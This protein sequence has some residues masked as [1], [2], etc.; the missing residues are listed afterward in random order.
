MIPMFRVFSSVKVRG[1]S[2]KNF[3]GFVGAVCRPDCGHEKGPG[4]PIHD[5]AVGKGRGFF[6]AAAPTPWSLPPRGGNKGAQTPPRGH[7]TITEGP[8]TP[9]GADPRRARGVRGPPRP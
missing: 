4:G 7:P 2:V 6:W 1:I 5:A 8:G 9:T 3:G